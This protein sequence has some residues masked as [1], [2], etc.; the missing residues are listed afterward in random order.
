MR[1]K[2]VTGSIATPTDTT[3]T[4]SLQGLK[5]AFADPELAGAQLRRESLG[6]AEVAV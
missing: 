1:A 4:P 3:A 6:L 5:R 2:L